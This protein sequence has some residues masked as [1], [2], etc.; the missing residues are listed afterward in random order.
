MKIPWPSL[1]T[2]SSKKYICVIFILAF[3]LPC[4][5]FDD[6]TNKPESTLDRKKRELVEFNS[7]LESEEECSKMIPKYFANMVP[8]GG[9]NKSEI[10]YTKKVAKTREQCV[11]LCCFSQECSV[12]FM[13]LNSTQITCFHVSMIKL[14]RLFTRELVEL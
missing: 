5:K 4:A 9:S 12:V 8:R 2:L 11:Q 3:F 7:A 14:V 1:R 13:F 10:I 6:Q